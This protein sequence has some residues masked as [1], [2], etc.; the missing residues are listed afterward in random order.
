MK[1]L[2]KISINS[3]ML[4]AVGLLIIMISQGRLFENLE[5]MTYDL[6][7]HL[8]GPQPVTD[9]I[10]VITIDDKTLNSL[11]RWPLPR[12]F[13]ASLVDV[14]NQQG[15]KAIVFDLLFSEATNFDETF[16]KSI[17][18]AHNV[19][20]P[21]AF[22]DPNSR[23]SD[24]LL[25]INNSVLAD[26]TPRLKQSA[27][28]VGHINVIIGPDGKARS[29]PLFINHQGSLVPQLA[30]RAA[31]DW[32]GLNINNVTMGRHQMIIDHKLMIPVSGFNTLM[33]NYPGRQDVSFRHV[34]YVDILKTYVNAQ[35]GAPEGTDLSYLR[36]KICFIGLTATGTSDLRANPIDN[37]C[38]MIELQASIFNSIIKRQFIKDAGA[39]SNTGINLIVFILS[40][41][42]CSKFPPSKTF[43]GTVTFGVT[44]FV[45]AVVLFDLV[46]LWIDLFFPLLLMAAVHLGSTSYRFFNEIKKRQILEKELEIAQAIQK[47]FLPQRVKG[48]SG[49]SVASFFKPAKFVA[50]DLYDIDRLDDHR[51][52][53]LIGDVSGKGVSA[54]LVMAQTISLFRMLVR[55]Q[56][57]CHDV[58]SALNKEL[59]G[60]CGGRFVTAF[61]LIVDTRTK[62]VSL[63]SA[64]HG[65]LFIY[66]PKTNTIEEPELN[67]N[68]PLGLIPE[69][70]YKLVRFTLEA[71]D[72]II[73]F[74]DGV[75]EARNPRGEEFG[76][77]RIRQIICQNGG[78][79]SQKILESLQESVLQFS[80]GTL[81]H[82]DI[83]LI[84]MSCEN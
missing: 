81:P 32:L 82:D 18:N 27:R 14:L 7:F 31:L 47:S 28:A 66:H 73:L 75:S 61:Y 49:V 17:A 40:L 30:F 63:S 38:P 53:V 44:Y 60:R 33:V 67:G 70:V 11:G 48:L 65:P 54:S 36:N 16:A 13:H 58:L 55:Q 84:V 56:G 15:A 80:S 52:G 76:L 42:I 29:V 71:D 4:I 25:T 20:L 57:G 78:N 19:Y 41:L 5:W 72:K 69:T 21:E 12:D 45:I 83:T 46:G 39:W 1:L 43:S 37:L 24:K 6:R 10:V 34:S 62:E 22:Y 50:G 3:G 59:C 74:S 79:P 2:P 23:R 51:I 35:Q 64:G 26:V 9:D 68:V 8:R 77:E